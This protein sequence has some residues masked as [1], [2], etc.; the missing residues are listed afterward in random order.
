MW[1][2]VLIPIAI[3]IALVGLV[4]L[5]MAPFIKTEALTCPA[6]GQADKVEPTVAVLVCPHCGIAI[7][8][9]GA[10]WARV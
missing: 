4:L 1:T 10:G 5:I 8:R 9:D 6:C 2:V 3:P 7:K